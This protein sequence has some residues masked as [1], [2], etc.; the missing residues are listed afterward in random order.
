MNLSS[1]SLFQDLVERSDR[2]ADLSNF[3]S[4]KD[5]LVFLKNIQNETVHNELH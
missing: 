1:P 4:L 2:G 5:V 3:L